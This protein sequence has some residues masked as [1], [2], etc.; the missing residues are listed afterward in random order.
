MIN[1][2]AR[3]LE[4]FTKLS[5]DDREALDAMAAHKVRRR[6]ARRDII[7]EGESPTHLNLILSGWACR[8]KALADGRR[9]IVAFFMPG[10]ICDLHVYVLREMDHSIG[11]ITPVTYAEVPRSVFEETT[12]GRPRLMQAMWW[13]SLVTAAIQREWTT[14]IGQRSAIERLGHLFLELFHR[15]ESVGLTRG[16]ECDLPLTQIELADAMGMTPVHVNRML[17]ELRGL[18]LIE[19]TGKH[20]VVP[21]REGL[22]RLAQFNPNYLHLQGEGRHLDANH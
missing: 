5:E 14:D 9:Q 11:A 3:K 16:N 18:G 21:D 10:D 19:L 4:R 2:L 6:E 15:Q 22:T 17:Q 1:P 20:L 7:R 13:D 8:Y 12:E